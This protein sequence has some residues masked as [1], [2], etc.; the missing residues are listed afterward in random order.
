MEHACKLHT[1]VS[2]ASDAENTRHGSKAW[3]LGG[4][5]TMLPGGGPGKSI[6]CRCCAAGGP[7]CRR[8]AGVLL[9]QPATRPT[10]A[11]AWALIKRWGTSAFTRLISRTYARRIRYIR[12]NVWIVVAALMLQGRRRMA[13]C[14]MDEWVGTRMYA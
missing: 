14:C 5:A 2:A 13:R 9:R 8:A 12:Q 3:A 4:D 11:E 6:A 10:F 1:V 7:I